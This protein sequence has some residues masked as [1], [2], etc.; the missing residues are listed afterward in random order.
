MTTVD[1]NKTQ[2]GVAPTL[3]P[4]KTIMGT[5]PTIEA[6][7]T[8]KPVQCP[9]CKTF[10]PVGVMF[11]VDCGLI[12]DRALEGDAFGAPA[13]QLPTLVD[14]SG[15][16]FYIRPGSNSVG[17]LGDLMIDDTRVSRRH[18]EITNSDGALIISDVGSTNGTKVNGQAL[19]QG[20]SKPIV[21]GDK[22]SFGGLEMTVSLPG[23]STKT[24]IGSSTRTQAITAAPTVRKLSGSLVAPEQTIEVF[25]GEHSFGR[26]ADNDIVIED[27]YAS[28]R[29]GKFKGGEGSIV[30]ID[31]GSTNGTYVN[32]VR[33]PK[34][35]ETVL[36]TGD[37]LKIGNLEFRVELA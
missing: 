35:T 36:K 5:A 32:T 27:P 15:R 31:T 9:V 1:P 3:D 17:R 19:G 14:G 20:E 12:F 4:N 11:C 28:S 2:M 25:Q 21:A 7:V 24:L 22:V 16:E 23:E 30:V 37:T 26:K 10:N 6:T 8:I 29:H 33:L 18:A 13:V 34:D